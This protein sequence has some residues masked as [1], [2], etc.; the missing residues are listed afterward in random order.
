MRFVVLGI[1][2]MAIGLAALISSEEPR[3]I[4]EL[5]ATEYMEGRLEAIGPEVVQFALGQLL[6]KA[7]ESSEEYQLCKAKAEEDGQDYL[8]AVSYIAF[9]QELVLRKQAQ[10]AVAKSPDGRIT[11]LLHTPVAQAKANL[12]SMEEILATIRRDHPSWKEIQEL[13]TQ[14]DSLDDLHKQIVRRSN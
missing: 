6:Q 10:A 1:V 5:Q 14:F 7:G 8:L 3:R 4:E 9:T 2:T 13:R 11:V 12:Q